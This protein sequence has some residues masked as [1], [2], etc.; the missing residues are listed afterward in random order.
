MIRSMTGFGRASGTLGQ[1]WAA[2][3]SIRSVNHRFLEVSARLPEALWE[4]ESVTRSLAAQTFSRGKLDVSVRLQRV[5]AS[6]MRVR[7]NEPALRELMVR[8]RELMREEGAMASIQPAELLGVPGIVETESTA[9]EIDEPMRSD[10]Q[11]LLRQ[12]LDQVLEMRVVEGASIRGELDERIARVEAL[13]RE[14]E[15]LRDEVVSEMLSNYAQRVAEIAARAGVE[16]D[17][18]RLAQET[19][20]QVERGDVAEE[21]S[22]MESHLDQMRRAIEAAEPSG[23]KLDFLSQELLREINTI[24]SKSRAASLRTLVVELKAEVERIREQ[25]QNVE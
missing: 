10:Y 23:K 5:G 15:T 9:Q 8:V 24:G 16:I 25:V 21:L 7:L 22:R 3:L 14:I 12:A 17:P 19:V 1:G 6:D 18:D 20:L 11:G 13:R 4:L 2:T